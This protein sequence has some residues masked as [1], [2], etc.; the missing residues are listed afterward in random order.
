MYE[1]NKFRS[2]RKDRQGNEYW[3]CTING[4]T[5]RL[6]TSNGS[7][8]VDLI[9]KGISEESMLSLWTENRTVSVLLRVDFILMAILQKRNASINKRYGNARKS[10][11]KRIR[12]MYELA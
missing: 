4:C 12:I 1:N 6:K 9:K 5:A 8:L 7:E 10:L 3:R 11:R 2:Y